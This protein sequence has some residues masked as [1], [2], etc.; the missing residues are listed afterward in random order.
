[1]EG[2]AGSRLV[3]GGVDCGRMCEGG[4]A[5]WGGS[6]P[7][8][9]MLAVRRIVEGAGAR[10]GLPGR[11]VGGE[12]PGCGEGIQESSPDLRVEMFSGDS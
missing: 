1:M 9:G 2:G 12:H 10:L 11:V 5:G 4:R 7:A 8:C 3:G 6:S